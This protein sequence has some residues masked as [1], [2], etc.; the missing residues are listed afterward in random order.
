MN[1]TNKTILNDAKEI[2][3][4]SFCFREHQLQAVKSIVENCIN[5]V[6]HTIMEAPTGS[7]KSITAIIAAYVLWKNFG[8]KSYILVSDLSLFSQYEHDLRSLK[9]DCFAWLK[10]KENYTCIKNGNSVSSSSCSLKGLGMHDL[11]KDDMEIKD[12]FCRSQCQYVQEYKQAVVKPITLMTYQLYFIQ[13]NYVEDEIF[14]GHNPN[15]PRRDL[16][17]CDE[18]HKIADICQSHFAPRIPLNRPEWMNKMDAYLK[19]RNPHEDVR[20]KIVQDLMSASSGD[21]ILK[22]MGAYMNYLEFYSEANFTLRDK[23]ALKDDLTLA[24]KEVLS[25]GNSARQ[26]H[27]KLSDMTMFIS[28]L[29]S[30]KYLVRSLGKDEMTMNFVFDDLLLMKFFHWKSKCELLMSATIGDFDDFARMTG[31][32]KYESI[33][34]PSEFDFA[35]SPIIWTDK[36]PMSYS[37]KSFSLPSICAQIKT[38]CKKHKADRGIIQTGNYENC[39]AL[40]DS[41]P[42]D[43]LRRCIFYSGASGKREAL[44]EFLERPGSILVGPTL[45]EGLNF[46]D[47]LCRFSICMKVPYAY[48]GSE[49]IKMKQQCIP[50]WYEYDVL[51][52]LQQGFGRGVR[53]KTDWCVNYILDGCIKNLIKRL[54]KMN[55]LAGRLKKM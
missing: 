17:I 38:I 44:E 47:D 9:I 13:R 49:Y 19:V 34:I 46:P 50:G 7:G 20:M 22:G 21:D 40:R 14:G 6:K 54:S 4:E 27:C 2:F 45:I 55:T 48:L 31:I 25:A 11:T 39:K 32:K 8:K 43:I 28:E 42:K 16:V 3:G 26:E 10:G 33:E 36:N 23:L 15:F 37:S 52:K 24:D 18:A 5:E 29:K 35:K 30:T 41:L 53:H 51:N 12:F 1:I